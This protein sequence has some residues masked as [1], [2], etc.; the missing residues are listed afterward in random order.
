MWLYLSVV[1]IIIFCALSASKFLDLQVNL[2]L[3]SVQ[4]LYNGYIA[5]QMTKKNEFVLVRWQDKEFDRNEIGMMSV[6]VKRFPYEKKWTIIVRKIL[7]CERLLRQIKKKKGAK[8]KIITASE[9]A[10]G[11]EEA[12][13]RVNA[14]EQRN[15]PL[16]AFTI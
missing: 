7:R 15:K 3:Y 16:M 4:K 2:H 10:V 8:K 5:K 14:K 12:V 9:C 6:I 13:A 11:R 1:S